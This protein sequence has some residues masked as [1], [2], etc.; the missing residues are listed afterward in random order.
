[1]PK[2][3]FMKVYSNLA[4]DVRK[5]VIVVIKDKPYSWNAAFVEVNNNTDL[6][7]EILKKLENLELI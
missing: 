7:K 1:M 6:A 5:E 2:D 4:E 3:S